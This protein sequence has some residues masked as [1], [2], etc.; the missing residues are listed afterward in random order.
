MMVDPYCTATRPWQENGTRQKARADYFF[1]QNT[2]FFRSHLNITV[3]T[4]RRQL[5]L[6]ENTDAGQRGDATAEKQNPGIAKIGE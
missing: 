4:I 6:A 3:F 2:Y 1:G 5:L